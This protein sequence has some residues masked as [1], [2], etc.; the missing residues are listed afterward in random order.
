MRDVVIVGGGPAGSAAASLLARNHDVTVL[1]EH[2][3][4]GVPLECTGLVSPEVIEMSGVKPTV[5]NTFSN[6]DIHFPDG[7]VFNIRC[8]DTAAVFIDRSDF[9]VKMAEKAMDAGAE[10]VYS[11][12]CIAYYVK[13]G[14]SRLLTS[15]GH[16]YDALLTVGADGHT[17]RIRKSVC[18]FKPD[19][20]VRGMQ[21]DI[22][23][24]AESQDTIQ[25]YTGSDI[26]PGFFAWA[27]PCGEITRVGMCNE[28]S[29]GV[30]SQYFDVLLGKLGLRDCE[31]VDRHVGKIPMGILKKT[32]FDNTMLIGD[33]A[34]QIKSVSGGGLYPILKCAPHLAKAAEEAFAARNFSSTILAHYQMNWQADIGKE[35]SRGFKL[36]RMYNNLKDDELSRVRKVV[37]KPFIHD[38]IDNASIDRPSEIYRKAMRHP[39]T[40]A[41]LLPLVL[42]G[43]LR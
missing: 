9:D 2:P 36:R 10:Y 6:A 23:Y 32:Y 18:D 8:K 26:A 15:T 30:P 33:A 17:S 11:E 4:S 12:R 16:S 7:G 14:S 29:M 31:I 28:W 24:E 42:K 3:E 41:R 34:C 27:I 39:F 22:K 5:L 20:L 38:I 13:N 40:F 35:L 37:E 43:V 1:E 25:I 19:M 21:A